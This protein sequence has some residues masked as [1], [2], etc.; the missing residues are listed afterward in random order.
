MLNMNLSVLN[1]TQ[2]L[3]LRCKTAIKARFNGGLKGENVLDRFEIKRKSDIQIATDELMN[4]ITKHLWEQNG[5]MNVYYMGIIQY[6]KMLADTLGENHY[7][8]RRELL[9]IINSFND[10][11]GVTDEVKKLIRTILDE[12]NYKKKKPKYSIGESFYIDYTEPTLDGER[13]LSVHS[14]YR[15]IKIDDVS[16]E[17][18]YYRLIKRN[19][20]DEILVREDI[21]DR[22]KKI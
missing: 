1:V 4:S 17:D 12:F 3:V 8:S 15:I 16:Y 9:D 7:L 13:V 22:S 18:V 11:D 14:N 20:T 19:G 10:C 6:L 5:Y 2:R 21:L